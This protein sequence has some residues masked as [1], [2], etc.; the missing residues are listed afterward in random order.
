MTDKENASLLMKA[1]DAITARIDSFPRPTLDKLEDLNNNL[2]ENILLNKQIYEVLFTYLQTH[3]C[4][5]INWIVG[6]LENK[7]DLFDN[8]P[9]AF[10][11]EDKG[12]I[13]QYFAERIRYQSIPE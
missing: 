4:Y 1:Q 10:L 8:H 11:V 12:D 3:P 6:S 7:V 2:P 9:L 13:K 5:L